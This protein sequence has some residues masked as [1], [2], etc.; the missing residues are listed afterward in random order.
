MALNET[1]Y[2]LGDWIE[3]NYNHKLFKI[4]KLLKINGSVYVRVMGI[5]IKPDGMV[6]GNCIRNYRLDKFHKRFKPSRAA[7][8]LY[9]DSSKGGDK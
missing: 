2:K 7:Q 9:K 8:I 5:T 4:I 3:H 1:A 6:E